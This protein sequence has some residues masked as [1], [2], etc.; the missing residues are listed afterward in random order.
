MGFQRRFAVPSPQTSV[1]ARLPVAVAREIIVE[2]EGVDDQVR[3]QLPALRAKKLQLVND[4]E[5]A[6]ARVDHLDIKPPL[7]Q[8]REKLLTLDTVTAGIRIS[9]QENPIS[10]LGADLVVTEPEAVCFKGDVEFRRHVPVF[11]IG[12]KLE[13]RLMTGC[14]DRVFTRPIENPQRELHQHEGEERCCRSQSELGETFSTDE[15]HPIALLACTSCF[16][17]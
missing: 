4:F 7:E 9:Q 17:A 5:P 8:V 10:T 13:G 3:L 11:Q 14:P 1:A 6:D 2:I 16:P 15:S 12:G